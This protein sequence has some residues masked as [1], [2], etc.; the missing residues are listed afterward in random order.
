[1][2]E[3]IAYFAVTNAEFWV[4]ITLIASALVLLLLAVRP[5]SE[6]ADLPR[7]PRAWR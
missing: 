3:I 5:E 7:G 6:Y 2:S 1:M 4:G